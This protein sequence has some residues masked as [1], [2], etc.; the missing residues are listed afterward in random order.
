VPPPDLTTF[1]SGPPMMSS[2]LSV[3]RWVWKDA[4]DRSVIR[5]LR[6]L[7]SVSCTGSPGISG[8]CRGL[9]MLALYPRAGGVDGAGGQQAVNL[10]GGLDQQVLGGGRTADR[11]EQRH[12]RQVGG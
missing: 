10:G 2:W 11:V 6:P 12:P 5:W 7:G 8:P 1:P 9:V 3:P 4:P